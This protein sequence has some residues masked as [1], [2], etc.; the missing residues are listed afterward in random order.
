MIVAASL[1]SGVAPCARRSLEMAD[2]YERGRLFNTAVLAAAL[3][4]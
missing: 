2:E 1:T 4:D 3:A